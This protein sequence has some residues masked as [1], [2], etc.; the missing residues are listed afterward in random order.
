MKFFMKKKYPFRVRLE[1]STLCQLNCRDCFMRKNKCGAVGSGFLKLVDFVAFL[2][3]NPFIKEIELSNNGE[4]FLNPQLLDILRVAYE[5]GVD[6]YASNGV[7]LIQ[8]L[9]KCWRRW[10]SMVLRK[11]LFLLMELLKKFIQ[12]TDEM[13]ILIQL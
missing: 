3:K 8:Y 4:I 2:D 7:N 9:M 5:R 1:A 13:V 6:I 11:L 12:N 10:L